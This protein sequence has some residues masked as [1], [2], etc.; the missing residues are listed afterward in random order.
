LD[1]TSLPG[2]LTRLALVNCDVSYADSSSSA[3]SSA[4]QLSLL[5]EFEVWRESTDLNPQHVCE[6]LRQADA[7]LKLK[8]EG[9]CRSFLASASGVLSQQQSLQHLEL[10]PFEPAIDQ[11]SS[12]PQAAQLWALTS[13]SQLTALQL[14]FWQVPAG[15]VQ[16]LFPAGRQL[17]LPQQLSI[18]YSA[19]G[20][21]L[22]P[23]DISSIVACC[24]SLRC[25][26]APGVGAAA[27]VGRIAT[28][29]LQQLRQLT[30][31]STLSISS[32]SWDPAAAAVLAG[33]IGGCTAVSCCMYSC[34]GCSAIEYCDKTWH[35]LFACSSAG[36]LLKRR[37]HA[38]CHVSD[39]LDGFCNLASQAC[40]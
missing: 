33:M 9:D 37:L 6:L 21:E 8:Y 1:L 32:P 4:V 5:Q 36:Q 29:E 13:S 26:S 22:E 25:L 20:W 31:L 34:D 35:S 17:Q 11:L 12:N 38:C 28:S 40:T 10:Q 15:A 14:G 18:G 3:S 24:P 39:M 30:A 2:S 23:G 19:A 16:Q 7:L 27:D